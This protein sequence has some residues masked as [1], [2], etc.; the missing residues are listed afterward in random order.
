MNKIRIAAVSYLNT[1]PLLYGIFNHSVNEKIDLQLAI[2]SQC[3]QLLASGEVDMALM[4][5]GAL[6]DITSPRLVSE[7]CIGANGPVRTVCLFSHVPIEEIEVVYLDYHSRTSVLLAK[8]LL[9]HYWK[10][11]V[12]FVLGGEHFDQHIKGTTAGVMI[13]DKTLDH[14]LTIPYIYD[15]AS[16]WNEMHGLPFVFAA[17]VSNKPLPKDFIAAFNEAQAK[18]IANIHQLVQL[19]ANTR[20]HFDLQKY[21]KENIQYQFDDAKREALKLFLDLT[22][23]YNTPLTIEI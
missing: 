14:E 19:M 21:Y 13:G 20:K 23:Q 15:L 22:A 2:P 10:K 16:A 17:W 11:N 8:Y 12:K 5:V 9:E 4:P 1:K 6:H 18:G 3:A 7:Y